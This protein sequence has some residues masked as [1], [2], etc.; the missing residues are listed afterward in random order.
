MGQMGLALVGTSQVMQLVAIRRAYR[1]AGA[2]GV[3]PVET[4]MWQRIASWPF[5]T[6]KNVERLEDIEY[7][8]GL[9]LDLYRPRQMRGPAPTL[10][11][12]HGGSWGGG[13]P[14]RQF[15]TVTHHLASRGWVVATVRYPLS[16]QATFPDHLVGVNR[17]IH[18]ARTQGSEWGIDPE[19]IAIAGGSAGAHLAALAALTNGVHQPGFDEADTSV[20]AAVVLYGIYDFFNRNRTRV[21]WPLIPVRVM[22][23]TPD[24]HP[25]LYRQASPLDQIHSEA[26]PFLVVHGTHDSL[27]PATE[28]IHFVDELSKAGV[29]VQ[30]LPIYGAQ[31]AF[32]VLGG[33][34]TRV[35]AAQVEQ[36]L[37]VALS[38]RSASQDVALPGR[39]NVS[40]RGIIDA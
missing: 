14:R 5:V 39:H 32:D 21:D 7:S 16:P 29:P 40:S 10:I 31:H 33:I 27:V 28:S 15:R 12:V 23:T 17:A 20:A 11:Y 35:L 38:G 37:N 3:E 4:P 30:Y 19:R 24:R 9:L 36:F 1:A 2:G 18:W 25:D 34:R 6:P 26:P 13:D 8:P 22:K